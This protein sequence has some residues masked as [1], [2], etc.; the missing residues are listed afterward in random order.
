M[1]AR[2]DWI[3]RLD[4][5]DVAELDA[6]LRS[7]KASGLGI[8]ALDR[9]SFRIPNFAQK[10]RQVLH[11]LE[12]GRGFVLLRGLPVQRYSKADAALIYWGI[13]AHLGP[14]VAQNAQGELLGHVR[15]VGADWTKDTNARGYQT[16]LHLPFHCDPTDVVGLLCLNKAKSGGQSRIVS[17]TAVHNEFVTRYPHLWKTMCEPFFRDRRGEQSE[18]Q[19]PYY[20]MPC[21][22]YLNGRP[23]VFYNFFVESAQRFPDVPRLTE[24][25]RE[26]LALMDE[27]SNDPAFYFDMTFEPGDIQF[28]CNYVTLHSRSD[29]EDWPEPER[30]RHLLRLWL[31][32]PAFKELPPAY[33]ER[34]SDMV[35][36]Q[37]NP[38][39]PVFDTTEIATELVG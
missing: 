3:V 23:F 39:P 9:E 14:A 26:A 32:T 28:L 35:A 30:K 31:R 2:D 38:R 6:A 29:Y 10:L 24:S 21:F 25:Q 13:G 20:A 4:D 17:S 27:L 5:T 34:N 7:A 37:R 33:A 12:D 1:A 8:P 15:N 22:N 36:W 16:K 11:D 18:G 19:R